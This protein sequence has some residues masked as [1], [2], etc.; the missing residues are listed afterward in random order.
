MLGGRY[1]L[2]EQI[3]RGGMS[4]VHRAFDAR[5]SRAVAVKVVAGAAAEDRSF[6]ERFRRE[7]QMLAAL[8]HPG[9]ATVYDAGQDGDQHFLVMEYLPWPTLR[10]M[11]ST[12]ASLSP[13]R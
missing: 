9:I 1:R 4:V 2:D 10:Q 12:G 3:G 5:L 6:Q 7:T 13:S 11:L 8:N